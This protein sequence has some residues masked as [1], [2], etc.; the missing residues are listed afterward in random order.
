M[1]PCIAKIRE[2]VGRELTDDEI[3]EL[4]EALKQRA[5][6]LR[7]EDATRDLDSALNQAATDLA[8]D[9]RI[10]AAIQ[11]RQALIDAEARRN[12]EDYIRNEWADRPD[13]GITSFLVGTNLLRKGARASVDAEQKQ[14]KSLYTAGLINDINALGHHKLFAS[15]S[16]DLEVSRVLWKMNEKGADLSGFSKQAKEIAEVVRKWQEKAR[17]D[18]NAAGAYI[19]KLDNYVVRQSHD[20]YK[21]SR[22]GK[23]DWVNFVRD[24]LDRTKADFNDEV[25]AE[26]YQSVSSGLHLKHGGKADKAPEISRSPANLAKRVSQEREIFFKDADA[27][28]EYNQR[29]GNGNLRE[30]VLGGLDRA[31]EATGLMRKL[32]TNPQYNLRSVLETIAAEQEGDARLRFRK[33][34]LDGNRATRFMSQLDGSVRIPGSELGARYGSILRAIQTMSKL[35]AALASS[36]VDIVNAA[37]EIKYQGGDGY[38]TAMPKL[39][40]ST[41]KGRPAGE[42]R[43]MLGSMGVF[44]DSMRGDIVTRFSADDSL[45]GAFSRAVQFFFKANGLQWWT[46]TLRSSATLMMSHNVAQNIGR[47][48]DELGNLKNLFESYNINEADWNVIRKAVETAEDGKQF[49]T[50]EGVLQSGAENAEEIANKLRSFFND[51]AFH[52]ILEP[53][54]RTKGVA[55]NMG[56][57]PG[58]KEGELVRFVMQFKSF[59]ATQLQ[60]TLGRE[61]FGRGVTPAAYGESYRGLKTLRNALR[62]GNGEKQAFAQLMLWMT[63]FGYG[64]MSIKD[65]LKG[66]EPRDPTSFKTWVGATAQGG[67][68]GIYGDFLFGPVNRFGGGF[69]PTVAGPTI[70]EFNNLATLGIRG[71]REGDDVAASAFNLA[72]NNTP[73]LNLFYTRLALDY[74]FFYQ[75]QENMNPGYLQRTEKRVKRDND[76][77][78]WLSPQD[79]S[80]ILE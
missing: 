51:R 39:I 9:A 25:L 15:G 22:A 66:R 46:E 3:R 73:F 29:F 13:L 49:S 60:K 68:L 34:Y 43:E 72:K 56:F 40:F 54:A 30:S 79:R 42:R 6:Q 80:R 61:I 59:P 16:M 17:L 74:L 53:D 50:P 4:L 27:W 33:E 37:S 35:G 2:I 55:L 32:G 26:I 57:R 44:L 48:F 45:P 28:F 38:L 7:R 14:L 78:F 64:A 71:V 5:A 63:L 21:I 76:Q 36:L 24:R 62:N 20:T 12:F 19:G 77:E 47:N 1:Q 18:A 65:M 31:G 8:K 11:K 67:A 58:T 70:S 23:D 52:A 75:M 69:L 41:L 10:G